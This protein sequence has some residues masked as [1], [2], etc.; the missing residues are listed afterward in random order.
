MAADPHRLSSQLFDSEIRA[1]VPVSTS[2][3]F[4]GTFTGEALT[5]AL[6]Y[7]VIS[8]ALIIISIIAT[9]FIQSLA[10][11]R[12]RRILWKRM[13]HT[14][15]SYYDKHDPSDVMSIVTNDTEIAVN[16]IVSLL[17]S[18]LPTLYLVWRTF[19]TVG[20]YDM[21][22][23][24]SVMVVIPLNVVISIIVGRWRYKAN[25]GIN[26][27]VG[28]LTGFLAERVANIPLI[29]S[30]TN[31]TQEAANGEIV[32]KGLYKAKLRASK[33][34]FAADGMSSVMDILQRSVSILFGVMLMG[35][36]DITQK[37]WI[38][39]FLYVN[40]LI[41][42]IN[43]L[44]S[45]WSSIKSAQGSAARVISVLEAPAEALDQGSTMPV[46]GDI[47]FDHVS[48]S[49]AEDKPALRDVSVTIPAGKATAIVGRCGS[50]KTTMISLIE[51]LYTPTDGCVTM[52]GV[53][54]SSTSLTDYRDCFAYV[55]Q[56]AGIFSGKLRSA[57]TTYLLERVRNL[58]L[59]RAGNMTDEEVREGSSLFRRM[60]SESLKVL[61]ADSLLSSFISLTSIGVIVVTF[62]IGSQQIAAGTM[63]TGMVVGFFTIAQMAGIRFNVLITMYG[64]VVTN[65]GVFAKIADVLE[66]EEESTEGQPLDVPDA[67]IRFDHVSF[68]YKDRT[69][70]DDL[71]CVIPKMQVTA[72]VGTNGAGKSTLFKLLCRMYE[73][74]QGCMYFGSDSADTFSLQ[75]WRKA[76]AMVAQDRPLLSGTIRENITYGC[77]RAITEAELELVAQQAG[78]L[79]LIRSLPAGFDTDVGPGGSNFSGGQRQCIA[80]ARAIMRNPDYLLLDEATSNLDAQSEQMVS[81]A[82]ANLMKGR[83]TIMIGHSL[84]AIRSATNL[85]VLKDGHLE[86]EGAP[87]DVYQRSETY[88]TFVD[89]QKKAA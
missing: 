44:V 11:M 87:E 82:L 7:Q 43:D 85:I 19:S 73:P 40:L 23:M 59:V 30:Y 52:G 65:N 26:R 41:P 3:L 61:G 83:T 39:F 9:S 1:R 86:A 27:Q 48:F 15:M 34:T 69:V 10:I 78:I 16:A 64:T 14:K 88:R 56:D 45:L 8:F 42:K 33:V 47:V 24:I 37:Q 81:A 6:L 12:G 71:S 57:M 22:L 84:S 76:F 60:F 77:D 4:S 54:I 79:E 55:Q 68:S 21:R 74:S 13:L 32:A 5:S 17:I 38:A 51:R 89:S 75:S 72:I 67:D 29:H 2:E 50:G 70:L 53:D 18:T 63:T 46:H 31:E 62:I 36:G 66:A 25:D 49:Y 80:I 20:N 58:R 28:A 35:S